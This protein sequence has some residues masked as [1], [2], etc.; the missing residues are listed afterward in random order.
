MP[1]LRALE[2]VIPAKAGIQIAKGWIPAFAGMTY[3]LV[4]SG[5][6][7]ILDSSSLLCLIK[8]E[9]GNEKVKAVLDRAIMSSVNVAEVV[10]VLTRYNVPKDDIALTIAQLIKEVL[11]FDEKQAYLTGELEK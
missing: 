9:P 5:W 1:I 7:S 4:S 8:K 10:W 2:I 6:L 11:A 3:C